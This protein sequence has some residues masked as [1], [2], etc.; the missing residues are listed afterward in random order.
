[1]S[2]VSRLQTYV[3]CYMLLF[4]FEKSEIKRLPKIPAESDAAKMAILPKLRRCII[5]S[6]NWSP[7]DNV[8]TNID[9][10]KPMP[11]RHATAKSIF[12]EALLGISPTFNFIAIQ[13]A[14]VMPIGL[15]NN[16]PK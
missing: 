11:P 3:I 10:V 5:T 13:L 15:P 16:N 1:M 7:N 14:M 12:H 8:S 9:I 6:G 2:K 4:F